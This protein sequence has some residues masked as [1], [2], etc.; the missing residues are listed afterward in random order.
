MPDTI[1]E[2]PAS[3]PAKLLKD[4]SLPCTESQLGTIQLE[5]IQMGCYTLS[6]LTKKKERSNE[7]SRLHPRNKHRERYNFQELIKSCTKLKQFVKLNAYNDLSVDFFNPEAV[8]TLNK[9]LLQ[10][11]YDITN[12]DIPQHY[13]CPSI[14]GR[15]DYIHNIA[16][17]LANENNGK[18]PRGNKIKCLDIG[19]GANCVYPIIGHNEYGWSFIGSDID[20]IAIVSAR[21][22]VELNTVLKGNVEV[23]T[24]DH[25]NN[26]FQG[27]IQKDEFIDVSICN[28]PFHTSLAEARDGTLRKLSNLTRK[29][30]NKS[31]LNF[32]GQNSELWCEGGEK[33]F[34]RDM[35]NQ[36]KL[37]STSCFWFSTLV[38]KQINLKSIYE[39]LKKA[40]AIEVKTIPMHQG[41]KTSRIV[42][43]TFLNREQQKKWVNTKWNTVKN[44]Q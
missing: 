14:P 6:M 41:N 38:A 43:W 28:P 3:A 24:Q 42:A 39:E 7:K 25:P 44:Q 29:K 40:N 34:V 16:D 5:P 12:W 26:I 31:V 2:P 22:I 18:I 20:P 1:Y 30:I 11:Y 4:N 8:K 36:S 9:A 13:L 21:K 37:F 17:L 19:V 32:G 33:I 23:R 27:I 35:I 10:H 15:A